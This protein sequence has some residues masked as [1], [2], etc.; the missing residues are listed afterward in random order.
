MVVYFLIAPQIL[1]TII[2]LPTANK[3]MKSETG[4]IEE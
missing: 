1:G 2:M 4:T 3:N